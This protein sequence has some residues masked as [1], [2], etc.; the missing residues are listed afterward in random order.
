MFTHS[1]VPAQN[2]P[3]SFSYTTD[4]LLTMPCPP[5]VLKLINQFTYYH[6]KYTTSDYN[7]TQL[8]NEFL[9]PLFEALGW[10]VYNKS[11]I[12]EL[13]KDVIH[14]D[15]VKIGGVIKAPD[16]SFRIGGTRKFF[17]EAKKPFIKI[18]EDPAPA[19]Q[20][21]RYGWSAK[22]P[23]SILTDFEEFAIYDCT[24]KPTEKDDVKK[25]RIFYCQFT[26]YEEKWEWISERF[27]K[28]G[29]LHG[30]FDEYVEDL[31][32]GKGG[33]GTATVDK[34]FLSSL[35]SWREALA[36]NIALRNPD[37]SIRELNDAVT[38]TIDRIVF[39]RI[40]EDRGIEQEYQ[41]SLIGEGKEVYSRLCDLFRYADD[42]FNSGLFHFSIEKGWDES[43]DE[44]TLSLKIDDKTLKEIISGL[45]YPKSQYEFS[46]MPADI[47]GKVYEQFLGKVIRLTDGHQA[48]VEEKPEV[49]KA[50]GVHY[51]PTYIV[52]YIVKHTIGEL[53]KDKTPKDVSLLR[54][55]DPA[56]GSGSFLIGAY[57]YLLD[58]HL[59]WYSEY[60][61]PH[62]ENGIPPNAKEITNLLPART[63]QIPVKGKKSKQPEYSLPIYQISK[64]DWKLTTDEKKRI[65]INNIY[66]VDIDPQAVE[67]T[68]LS[69]LLKVLEGER[70]EL[71]DKQLKITA[72]RVLP[73]LYKN[74]KCGNSLIGSDILSQ[75]T[76]DDEEIYKINP[77]DWDREF[78]EIM[79]G[80]GF[81]AVIG[82][83]PYVRI[84]RINHRESDYL[85]S[86]YVTPTSKTDISLIFIEKSLQLLSNF[87]FLGFI[88]TSQWLSTDYGAKLRSLLAN[89]RIK[90]IV[91]FDSLPVF[92]NI[93]T[94]PAIFIM[95][96]SKYTS[97][98]YKKIRSL[99]QLTLNGIEIA[100]FKSI[101][102]SQYSHDSWIIDELD[103]IN[104]LKVKK[105]PWSTL[106]NYAKTY[107]GVLTGMDECFVVDEE[108]ILQYKLERDLLYPYAYRG[109][110]VTRY[111]NIHPK[112][113]IIYPYVSNDNLNPVLISE[114]VLKSK[115][116]NIFEYLISFKSQLKRRMDSR[117][118]Y[119][120]GGDWYR[121]LRPGSFRYIF[122]KKLIIKGV[123]KHTNLGLLKENSIFNGANTPGIINYHEDNTFV[124]FLL[125]ILNSNT[126]SYYLKSV[127]PPKLNNYSRFNVKNINKIPIVTPNN[128]I[129]NEIILLVKNLLN[130]NEQ[131]NL[132]KP[133]HERSVI[134]RQIDATE[135]KIDKLVY[136]LYDLTEDEIKIIEES[137]S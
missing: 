87:G 61:A 21:R 18:K 116:P 6:S 16:Y 54:F 63:K 122:P 103:L 82:N 98:Q 110:E 126:I 131:I 100:P 134:E 83:P 132:I 15:Q 102:F 85:Y 42:K 29:I 9:N 57:Q 64:T 51:T 113:S 12:S 93:S 4:N 124:L 59:Q 36:K 39:L 49:R 46:V 33:K 80:G 127:C 115:Y 88:S 133:S 101:S 5:E 135:R 17:V 118:L 62:I 41:L 71:I 45:Y 107:V 114:D 84:H 106:D 60:L 67:V 56:C 47:L 68:K 92:E 14:E 130:L 50:G 90:E 137:F 32:K 97:T 27:S 94:Y 19:L 75:T 91:D 79:Q 2:K 73:S 13:Y 123:D 55:L 112:S 78:S 128:K 111:C 136:Q 129:V 48:K 121:H 52:E 109:A 43:P 104:T 119:A 34:D 108:K 25:A 96:N 11:G 77:F 30:G 117:R 53:I 23:V 65:L 120:E 40:C 69:L 24:I 105:I 26:E 3:D 66:G 10:D 7:E 72:E 125:G 99:K 31:V 70:S 95:G 37:L 44:L 28:N 76:L 20:I 35:E 38:K 8:R 74:I 89:N 1:I 81:D 22:L 86:N 58:W